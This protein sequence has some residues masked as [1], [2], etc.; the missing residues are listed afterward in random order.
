MKLISVAIFSFA[1]ALL[2]LAFGLEAPAIKNLIEPPPAL[3]S[4]V[5]VEETAPTPP[6]TLDAQSREALEEARRQ[7]AAALQARTETEAARDAARAHVSSAREAFEASMLELTE[8]EARLETIGR[9][10]SR[11]SRAASQ[12]VKRAREATVG[13]EARLREATKILEESEA[14]YDQAEATM[15][16][17]Q[18]SLHAVTARVWVTPA[19]LESV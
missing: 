6:Q 8:A 5:V 15:S 11:R 17:A 10:K 7:L 16:R 3:A 13:A 1:I 19:L 9:G 14:A 18:A 4:E 2:A 12:A